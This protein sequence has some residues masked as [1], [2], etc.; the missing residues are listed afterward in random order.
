MCGIFHI[1]LTAISF[2][3]YDLPLHD[4]ICKR[5][6]NFINSGLT[7][8][9]ELVKRLVHRGIHFERMRSPVGRNALTCCKRYGTFNIEGINRS[10][11]RHWYESEVT[12]ELLNIVLVLLEL[13]FIRDGSFEVT[14]NEAAL[15]SRSDIISFISLICT[16]VV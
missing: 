7:S 5:T 9:C 4:E 2:L 14:A 6:A 3:F 8:D 13:I 11:V 1:I 16:T 15:Y 12:E 10:T